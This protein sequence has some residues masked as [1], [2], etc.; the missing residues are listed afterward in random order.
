MLGGVV[1]II[2]N[3]FGFC[4]AGFCCL[5]LC[6]QLCMVY[7]NY[8]RAFVFRVCVVFKSEFIIRVPTHILTQLSLSFCIYMLVYFV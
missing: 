6:I 7:F 8:I 2:L 3:V 1:C 5:N 4:V